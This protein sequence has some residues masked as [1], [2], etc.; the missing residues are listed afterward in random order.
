MAAGDTKAATQYQLQLQIAKIDEQILPL[1]QQIAL[2]EQKGVDAADRQIEKSANRVGSTSST[3]RSA[4]SETKATNTV[5]SYWKASGTCSRSTSISTRKSRQPSIRQTSAR[6][7]GLELTAQENEALAQQLETEKQATLQL[8]QQRQEQER[9]RIAQGPNPLTINALAQNNLRLGA[10]S[11]VYAAALAA[12]RGLKPGSP[13]YNR[14]VQQIE[15][16]DRLRELQGKNLSFADQT[17]S[18]QTRA[19]VCCPTTATGDRRSPTKP[20]TRDRLLAS[21]SSRQNAAGDNPYSGLFGVPNFQ[22]GQFTAPTSW[23][24][25]QSRSINSNPKSRYLKK[26][27]PR[28]NKFN[29]T[30]RSSASE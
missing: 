6:S 15:A 19:M 20:S 17:R 21:R 14:L 10:T 8:E 2:E 4:I 27:F 7:K 13:E 25:S 22:T 3:C 18:R 24:N 26:Q 1:K 5:R 12:S 29:K 30:P 11:D 16:Q 9:Q 28:L 23:R